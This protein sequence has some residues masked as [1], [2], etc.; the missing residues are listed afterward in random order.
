MLG[1][2]CAGEGGAFG[3]VG[4]L[5]GDGSD[6]GGVGGGGGGGGGCGGSLRV[7]LLATL[8][9]TV[10]EPDLREKKLKKLKN[11]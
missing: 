8:G 10:L 7:V 5:L 1:F 2:L 9:T 4:G 11:K 6:G 3:G